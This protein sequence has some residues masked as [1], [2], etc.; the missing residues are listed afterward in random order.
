V[1]KQWCSA[2]SFAYILPTATANY[3]ANSILKY[4]ASQD[5]CLY[6]S[7]ITLHVL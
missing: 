1:N 3:K 4:V 5:N 6:M 7:G 2:L